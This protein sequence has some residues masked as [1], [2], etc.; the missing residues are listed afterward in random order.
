MPNKTL[1]F[2]VYL[3]ELCQHKF[4]GRVIAFADDTALLYSADTWTELERQASIDLQKLSLW[5][6]N[7]GLT[8]N[9]EKTNFLPFHLSKDVEAEKLKLRIHNYN[10]NI[11]NCNRSCPQIERKNSAK[12]LGIWFDSN[13]RWHSHLNMLNKTCRGFLQKLFFLREVPL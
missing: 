8:L 12:Y 2:I 13:L 9:V 10:C 4:N 7:R 6:Q 5:F 11:E 1:L 3:N